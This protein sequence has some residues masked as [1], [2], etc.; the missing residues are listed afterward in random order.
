MSTVDLYLLHFDQPYKHARH[1]L[2]ITKVGIE[3]RI[4]QHRKGEG[5]NITRILKRNGITFTVAR[6]WLSVPRM[7]ENKIKG[8]GLTIYCPLCKSNPRNPRI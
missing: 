7:S 2:G 4:E 1:Y 8:R 5:A 6:T 3:N